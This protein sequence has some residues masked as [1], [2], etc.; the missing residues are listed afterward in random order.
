MEE[1]LEQLWKEC[2]PYTQLGKVATYIP[3]LSKA[4]PGDFGIYLLLSNGR[5]YMIGNY[6]KNFT[7]QS[8]V[9]PILLLLAL[10]D[11]GE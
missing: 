4:D 8:V 2:H 6:E 7:M 10:M 9:K 1:L 11:N 3:E 5:R